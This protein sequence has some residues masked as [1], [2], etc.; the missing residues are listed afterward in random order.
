MAIYTNIFDVLRPICGICIK[1]III[2]YRNWINEII[3]IWILTIFLIDHA[4]FQRT[5]CRL[6]V[7]E[8]RRCVCKVVTLKFSVLKLNGV[9]CLSFIIFSQSI[10]TYVLI[11]F[12]SN[13][14]NFNYV[15]AVVALQAETLGVTFWVIFSMNL[16][17]SSGI[18]HSYLSVGGGADV[19]ASTSGRFDLA[20]NYCA[21][22]I[23]FIRRNRKKSLSNLPSSLFDF[24]KHHH[25]QV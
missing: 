8:N 16:K 9:L 21:E 13:V 12:Q 20:T 14:W 17:R 18:D 6:T 10:E 23:F 24:R 7:C 2:S 19:W 11:Q 15:V 3:H 4:N 22:F 5:L 25:S 1:L